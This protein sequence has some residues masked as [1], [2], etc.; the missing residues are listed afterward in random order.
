VASLPSL[1]LLTVVFALSL[2]PA[3]AFAQNFTTV[4]D[5]H[6]AGPAVVPPTGSTAFGYVTAGVNSAETTVYFG[7]YFTGLSG[8]NS[9]VHVHAPADSGS[10]G[11]IVFDFPISGQT[12]ASSTSL[13]AVSPTQ[14]AHL[15]NGLWYVDVHSAAFPNGEIRGNFR[16][17]S[18]FVGWMDGVQPL[19]PSGVAATGV[20][21]IGVDAL[22]T[23]MEM[24]LMVSYS[25]LSGTPMGIHIHG[26]ALPGATG[27]ILRSIGGNPGV[28]ANFYSF[29]SI[30]PSELAELRAGLWY[31]DVHSAAH[32]DGELRG[33]LKIADKTTE[34]DGDGRAEVGVFR[35]ASGTWYLQNPATGA[36]SGLQ[37]GLSN[38]DLTPADFDGDGR[39]DRAV[40][41]SGT[42]YVWQSST[43]SLRVQ[44]FGAPTDD[45]RIVGD[46]D[47]DGKA[48]FAVWREAGT[49]GGASFLYVLQSTNGQLLTIQWGTQD[50]VALVGDHDG[51]RRRD[52]VVYRPA[53]GTYYVNRSTGGFQGQQW[54]VWETDFVTPGDYD[55][56]GQTDFA[57]FRFDGPGAGTWYILRSSNGTLQA[58]PFGLGS[59][60]PVPG[61]YDGD[62]KNDAAVVRFVDG[63]LVWYVNRSSNGT[64]LAMPFGFT[65]D[66]PVQTYLIR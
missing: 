55:A 1:R 2:V 43:N 10:T 26:P 3:A 29:G 11:P 58:T 27:P 21:R 37:F 60:Y 31:F 45:P 13:T 53:S 25:T 44:P 38:D 34:F 54:G 65:S 23:P 28:N 52:A 8:P 62:G 19:T 40:W 56:D 12:T 33:Q 14:L 30:T 66:G 9:S 6:L 4:Y 57:V 39:T 64:L 7:I 49:V 51:D 20:A 17:S 41:R 42:F 50:D 47:G 35:P 32:P 63:T 36:F 61:D 16:P 46:F 22:S 18:P 24:F 15:K 5:A 48:D 59:D